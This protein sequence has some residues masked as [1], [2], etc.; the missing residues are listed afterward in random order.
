MPRGRGLRPL[1]PGP[2]TPGTAPP[3]YGGGAVPPGGLRPPGPPR[4]GLALAGSGL[5]RLLLRGF[6]R[7]LLVVPAFSRQGRRPGAAALRARGLRPR[8]PLTWALGLLVFWRGLGAAVWALAGLWWVRGFLGCGSSGRRCSGGPPMPPAR[9]ALG[10]LSVFGRW[11]PP[12]CCGSWLRPKLLPPIGSS[13]GRM[14]FWLLLLCS[15]FFWSLWAG[16]QVTGVT[17]ATGDGGC[18]GW[19]DAVGCKNSVGWGG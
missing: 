18:R 2:P 11:A 14:W 17:G 16:N 13:P 5:S 7:R 15:S 6:L 19:G 1:P 8:D 9:A 12:H 10:E 3:P 4:D